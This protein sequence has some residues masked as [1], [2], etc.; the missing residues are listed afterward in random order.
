MPSGNLIPQEMIIFISTFLG[1]CKA[2]LTLKESKPS[3]ETV[4]SIR[5]SVAIGLKGDYHPMIKK[6]IK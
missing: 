2:F 5:N 4:Y 3:I 6:H 1:N